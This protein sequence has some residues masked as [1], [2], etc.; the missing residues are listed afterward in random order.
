MNRDTLISVGVFDLTAP[1]TIIKPDSKGR[2]QS[3]MVINQDHSMPPVEHGAGEFTL[4]KEKVGT[5]YLIVIFRTFV[6][7][8]D[9][10]DSK[11][12]NALQEE[13]AVRQA[14]SGT[15]KIPDW[16]AAS[17][18]KVRDAIKVLAA[19]RTD[20]KGMFGD[21]AKLNPISHLLGTAY[22]W[23]GNPEESAIYDIVVPTKNDG[24]T[25]YRVTVKHVPV[26]GFWSITVYN[27]DGFMEKNAQNVYSYNNV[28]AKKNVDGSVT[29]NFGG[30]PGDINNLPITPG[31]NYIVRMYQPKQEILNGT[32][33][34]PRA[35]PTK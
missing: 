31:W 27:N 18:T 4:T 20:S 14:N 16:D 6:D 8:N 11:A 26:D 10:A 33:S 21:K 25:P 22:G 9:P 28:T 19:T 7:A 23:G 13:I 32:W 12:A 35:Q 34:F 2:F 24:M 1:V 29:I 15:F 3:M 5:R 17:L 30:D